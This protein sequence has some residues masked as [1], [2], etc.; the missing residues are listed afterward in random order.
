MPTTIDR[1][2]TAVLIM[3]YQN[4]ILTR[5]TQVDDAM[6]QRA[7][8]VL[9]AAIALAQRRLPEDSSMTRHS[10][11]FVPGPRWRVLRSSLTCRRRSR[12]SDW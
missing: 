1:E 6:L 12:F 4:D 11:P 9:R 5:F 2:R 7:A 8:D 3:D 10:R